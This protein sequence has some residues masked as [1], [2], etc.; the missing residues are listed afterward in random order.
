M[1]KEN[2]KGVLLSLPTLNVL[3]FFLFSISIKPIKLKQDWRNWKKR[4]QGYQLLH[5][6]TTFYNAFSLFPS[7]QENIGISLG[8]WGYQ[9]TSSYGMR[10]ASLRDSGQ[11]QCLLRDFVCFLHFT[12]VLMQTPQFLQE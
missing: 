12:G 9:N 3:F 11:N 10:L 2:Y 8:G 6:H 1:F 5:T 7:K 4:E